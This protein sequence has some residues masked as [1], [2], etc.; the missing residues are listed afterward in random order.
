MTAFSGFLSLAMGMT[1]LLFALSGGET[2]VVSTISATTP[3]II[4]PLLWLRTGQ[5]P[6]A[7]A[8]LGALFVVAGLAFIM[9]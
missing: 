3:V 1:L 9:Y 4:L 8:W 6:A 7:G 5:R 2:G